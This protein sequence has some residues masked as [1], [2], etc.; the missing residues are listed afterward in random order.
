MYMHKRYIRIGVATTTCE[1]FIIII[2]QIFCV[3]NSRHA[4]DIDWGA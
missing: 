2:L 4:C 1:I 3:M